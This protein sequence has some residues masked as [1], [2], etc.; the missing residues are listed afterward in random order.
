MAIKDVNIKEELDRIYDKAKQIIPK[1][2]SCF[3]D[4]MDVDKSI[5]NKVLKYVFT[6]QVQLEKVFLN[7][8]PTR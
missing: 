5:Y 8:I 7:S 4:I 3:A 2:V 1:R 6:T